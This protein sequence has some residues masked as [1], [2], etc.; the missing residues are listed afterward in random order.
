MS[1]LASLIVSYRFATPWALLLLLV[2]PFII[3]RAA[4]RRTPAIKFPGAQ[5][6]A[7]AGRTWRVRLRF[8]PLALRTIALVL[9]VLALARPQLGREEVN[10]KGS[11]IAI[12]TA[13]D[14]SSSMGE[15]FESGSGKTTRFEAAK[16]ILRVFIFGDGKE[17]KGRP[18]DL[19]G[20]IAFAGRAYTVCPLTLSH[21]VMDRFID[22]M[23][24]AANAEEDG[25]GMGDGLALAAARVAGAGGEHSGIKSKIVV[26]IT[27]GNNNL[28]RRTPE[29]AARLARMWGVKVYAIGVGPSSPWRVKMPYTGRTDVDTETLEAIAAQTGGAFWMA[30]SAERLHE[31]YAEIDKFE[32][33]EIEA[34]S[35]SVHAERFSALALAALAALFL[36]QVLACTVFRRSP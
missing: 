22:E 1:M 18:G 27:D 35:F 16:K 14:F 36:E 24:L 7:S 34:T 26:L 5:F 33:S 28:G 6:A 17:L 23:R 19:T 13:L 9:I 2:V 32:K 3:R 11:G 30:E 15:K 31:I 8:I 20:I 12:E 10:E 29:Q 21:D 4:A 25:T